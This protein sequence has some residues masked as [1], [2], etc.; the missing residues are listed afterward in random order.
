METLEFPDDPRL[1]ELIDRAARGETIRLKHGETAVRIVPEE[2]ATEEPT[3]ADKD[4]LNFLIHEGPRFPEDFELP[5]RS[6]EMRDP[7]L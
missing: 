2:K 3:Q 7:G 1:N 5:D 6:G 4:F